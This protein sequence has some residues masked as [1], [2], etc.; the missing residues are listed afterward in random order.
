MTT[1]NMSRKGLL[2]KILKN[3][4]KTKRKAKWSR[5][6]GAGFIKEDIRNIEVAESNR[7][8]NKHTL[9]F[10]FGWNQKQRLTASELNLRETEEA[11]RWVEENL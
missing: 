9:T 5:E 11:L 10:T 4:I 3:S 1:Q 6:A 8:Q 2:M 7:L